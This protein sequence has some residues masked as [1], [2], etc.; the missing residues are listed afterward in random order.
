MKRQPSIPV[1][2]VINNKLFGLL[3]IRFTLQHNKSYKTYTYI[4]LT[5]LMHR[6]DDEAL[7]VRIVHI[8]LTYC[9]LLLMDCEM[10]I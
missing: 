3:G 8:E 7:I 2:S 1:V 9:F 5:R 4:Y 6:N 10:E